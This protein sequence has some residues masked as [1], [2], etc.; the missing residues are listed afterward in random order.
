MRET[1]CSGCQIVVFGSVEDPDS[2][3][4]VAKANLRQGVQQSSDLDSLLL[5]EYIHNTVKLQDYEAATH[6]FERRAYQPEFPNASKGG[7]YDI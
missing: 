6:T 5:M 2:N 7:M 1:A 3:P 4:I